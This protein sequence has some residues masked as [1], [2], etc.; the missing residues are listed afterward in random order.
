LA[1]TTWCRV[2]IA[3]RPVQVQRKGYDL[4][5]TF[6][7]IHDMGDPVGVARHIRR[8]LTDDGTWLNAGDGVSGNFNVLGRFWYS[9]STFLCV[10]NALSQGGTRV[11][12]AAAGETALRQVATEGGFTRIRRAAETPF[13]LVLEA[14]PLGKLAVGLHPVVRA[15]H[16]EVRVGSNQGTGCVQEGIIHRLARG[17]A[18]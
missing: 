12:G 1:G 9:A 5:C 11:L 16:P 2:P 17:L 3:P 15:V 14:R 8:T 10:P 18:Q 13:N 4:I 7:G 6:D